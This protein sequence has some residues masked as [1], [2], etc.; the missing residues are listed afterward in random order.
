MGQLDVLSGSAQSVMPAGL[1]YLDA[2]QAVFDGMLEGWSRQQRTRFLQSETIAPRLLLVRRL[3]AFGNLYP[4]QW[5]PG[6]MEA[7]F[8]HLRSG[9]RPIAYSTARGYQV[10][11]RMFNEY[12]VDPRYGWSQI[13]VDRFGVRPELVF[14]EWNTITHLS[15]AEGDPRRR[16]LSYDEVQALFD[17]ADGLVEQIRGRGR[18]GALSAQRDAAL[19]KVIY[20]FGLR[21]REAVML[22]VNDLGRNPKMAQYGKYGA[23]RVRFAKAAGGGP[24]R[25][26]TVLTVPEMD[27]VVAVLTDWVDEVR[28]LFSPGP[29]PALWVT[30]RCGRMSTRSVEHAFTRAQAAAGL[31]P[32]LDLHCLRH[33]YI[34]HLA[35]FDYP[36]QFIQAQAG[37]RYS[38]STGIYT[39]V[40]DEYRNR[41][42]DRTLHSRHP[43]LAAAS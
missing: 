5:T 27:W 30:E 14:H 4:W 7:F 9:H 6:E 32:A 22:D 42:L 21:R 1:A 2:Q 25:R 29:H 24:P 13:C 38:S 19:L 10:T 23:I 26:R 37:H 33:S 39:H 36:H 31:D 43:A 28:A 12:V 35:E 18:K 3:V 16:S 40:S 15:E 17:A 8:D 11:L 20:A 41:L 34:T